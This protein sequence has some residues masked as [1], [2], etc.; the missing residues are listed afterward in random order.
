MP[1]LE[2]TSEACLSPPTPYHFPAPQVGL[3]KRRQ[4]QRQAGIYFSTISGPV[5]SC[6]WGRKPPA[7]T[8]FVAF[9]S[10]KLLTKMSEKPRLYCFSFP[11]SHEVQS[12]TQLGE[13]IQF[14]IEYCVWFVILQ[15]CLSGG[16]VLKQRILF[17]CAKIK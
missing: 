7:A 9:S 6:Q 11:T 3:S 4:Q 2:V 17:L 10:L 16:S 15:P 1:L 13:V 14:F 5:T 8:F 12:G